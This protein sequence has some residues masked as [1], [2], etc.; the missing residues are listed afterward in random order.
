MQLTRAA[1]QQQAQANQQPE[2]QQAPVIQQQEQQQAPVNQQ[3]ERQQ[4]RVN[5]QLAPADNAEQQQ[6]LPLGVSRP[7]KPGGHFHSRTDEG[8]WE[9]EC[10]GNG[11]QAGALKYVTPTL[12]LWEISRP[13]IWGHTDWGCHPLPQPSGFWDVLPPQGKETERSRLHCNGG[14]NSSRR[15]LDMESTTRSFSGVEITQATG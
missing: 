1:E 9:A 10:S 6:Q 7:K 2:Q 14:K 13:S 3:P 4:A 11:C 15:W 8:L 5:Q 12:Q